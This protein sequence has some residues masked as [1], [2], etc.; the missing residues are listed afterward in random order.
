MTAVQASR[1]TAVG[2]LAPISLDELVERAA[3]LTR[4]DR[5][6]VVPTHL[7]DDILTTLPTGTRVLEIDGRRRF[8]Y[9]STYL[10]TP[11]HQSYL[12]AGRGHRHRWKVRSR[13]YLDTGDCWLEVKTR[14]TRGQN[15]KQR[16]EHPDAETAG[17]LTA[18]GRAF[19]G[20]VIGTTATRA[21][22]PVLVTA[23][24][25][26]TLFLPRSASR[27]TIDVD[28]GWTALDSRRDL[29]RPT[30]A[31]VETKT[32]STPSEMDRLLWRHGHRPVRISK[33][34]VGMAALDPT[35]PRLKWH[36]TLHRHLDLPRTA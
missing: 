10:D 20:D 13:S 30:L 19:V 1:A 25:R 15:L 8:G 31:V 36:H 35:L 14:T 21:L 7:L 4:V 24:Q 27:V 5:K 17:G 3:L 29:D 34:G 26:T 12:V 33:Y 6:Y 32:G 23:Y 2:E 16:I 18:E 9:R 28:L 11:D 22:H